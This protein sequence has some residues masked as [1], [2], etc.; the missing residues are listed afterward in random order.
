M[1]IVKSSG[2]VWIVESET[3]PGKTYTVWY[4][5]IRDEWNCTC[6]DFVFRFKKK[7]KC[8]HIIYV[9]KQVYKKCPAQ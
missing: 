6:P 2:R 1:R 3:E 9:M 4:D 7:R 8:K 5:P